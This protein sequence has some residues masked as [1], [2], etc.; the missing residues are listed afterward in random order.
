M[1]KN[2]KPVKMVEAKNLDCCAI[3]ELCREKSLRQ[4]VRVCRKEQ[5]KNV[6]T[7]HNYVATDFVKKVER[8]C[9]ENLK[10]CRDTAKTKDI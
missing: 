5:L 8:V 6:A 1:Q 9:H 10:L 4:P 7:F 3:Y 2:K